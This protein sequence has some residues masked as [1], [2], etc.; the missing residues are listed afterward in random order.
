MRRTFQWLSTVALI[1][2]FTL[3][4]SPDIFSKGGG[5]G[6]SSRSS[7]SSRR[8]A[9]KSYSTPS[10][11]RSTATRRTTT[12]GQRSV[13]RSTATTPR[14]STGTA[15][16]RSTATRQRQTSMNR[17]RTSSATS[18]RNMTNRQVRSRKAQQRG[19]VRQLKA[20]NRQLKRQNRRLQRDN[21]RDRRLNREANSPITVNNFGTYYPM[22]GYSM[23]PLASSMVFGNLMMGIYFHDYYNHR[24]R[25]SWMWHYHHRDYDRSHWSKEKQ[26]EYERWRAYYDS[27]NIKPDP[28]YVD[29]GTNRDEDYIES[30]VDK[31]PDKFYGDE[32]A[33][34]TVDELPDEAALRNEVMAAYNPNNTQAS[35][36]SSQP[37]RVEVVV[38]KKTSGCT[39]FVLLFGSLLIVGI[40]VLVMYNKGYF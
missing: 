31:N 29:P 39:W 22:A 15:T 25:H 21:A 19:Q 17:A 7:Y 12:A 20:Q 28:N 32:A 2:L 5:F 35:A 36:T 23:Y 13:R 38:K 1:I 37:Q 3:S 34:V 40:I 26:M 14:S 30:Y 6:R 11:S 27:Q 4:T 18:T 10:R 24:L 16:R 9:T 8:S 33:Q